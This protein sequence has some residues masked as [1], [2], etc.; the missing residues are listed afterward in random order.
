[1]QV[2]VQLRAVLNVVVKLGEGGS[3]RGAKE[4][5]EDQKLALGSGLATD[6]ALFLDFVWRIKDI[7]RI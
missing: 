6:A 7:N 4:S 2:G 1:V 5:P 3:V